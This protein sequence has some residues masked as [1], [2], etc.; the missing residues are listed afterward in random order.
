MVEEHWQHVPISQED[1]VLAQIL[2][3]PSQNRSR[4]TRR[5]KIGAQ[6][7]SFFRVP[8]L[9]RQGPAACEAPWTSSL[10]GRLL[11]QVQHLRWHHLLLWTEIGSQCLPL[12]PLSLRS[13]FGVAVPPTP[14]LPTGLVDRRS[15]SEA[16][17]GN[18]SQTIPEME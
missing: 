14:Y 11:R 10:S 3:Q 6:P 17:L 5:A 2:R 4:R 12:R 13:R 9:C 15:S 7:Q 1:D 18:I 16:D 8:C